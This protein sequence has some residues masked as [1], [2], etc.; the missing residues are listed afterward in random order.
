MSGLRRLLRKAK[1]QYLLV[2][3]KRQL[4]ESSELLYLLDFH[5]LLNIKVPNQ[6]LYLNC[7][8]ERCS[9]LM[10]T[11]WWLL[12]FEYG[13]RLKSYFNRIDKKNGIK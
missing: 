12:E 6:K 3:Y 5:T 2:W 10:A 8:S 7:T 9:V 13:G 4:E 11:L 1:G